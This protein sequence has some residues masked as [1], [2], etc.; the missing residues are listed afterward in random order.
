MANKNSDS[1]E[2]LMIHYQKNPLYRNVYADGAIGGVTP[3]GKLNLNF[4]A[5]RNTIPKSVE[6]DISKDGAISD[7]KA[8]I[9]NGKS[10]LVREIEFSIYLDKNT[11]KD[12]Y[13]F[14]KLHLEDGQ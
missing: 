6:Y 12:L 4:Y 5:T 9:V 3:Q 11:A 2:K 14:L 1:K 13:S 10:G 8:R 7:E